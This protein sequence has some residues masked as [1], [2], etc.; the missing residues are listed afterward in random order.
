MKIVAYEPY[1]NQDDPGDPTEWGWDCNVCY[2][3]ETDITD[4]ATA[5]SRAN[6]H[7]ADHGMTAIRG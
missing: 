6:N 1:T 3:N 7:A 2:A 5:A 4:E